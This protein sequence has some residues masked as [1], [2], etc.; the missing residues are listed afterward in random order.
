MSTDT[1]YLS[2]APVILHYVVC[3]LNWLEQKYQI[4]GSFP[5]SWFAGSLPIPPCFHLDARD[6]F[7][8]QND[9]SVR[10][11]GLDTHPSS[12]IPSGNEESVD[13]SSESMKADASRSIPGSSDGDSELVTVSS[14]NHQMSLQTLYRREVL[15]EQCPLH[16]ELLSMRY[17]KNPNESFIS[18]HC[19]VC[20]LQEEQ[21]RTGVLFR[22]YRVQRIVSNCREYLRRC[23]TE[24]AELQYDELRCIATA[25]M[26]HEDDYQP[27][28]THFERRVSNSMMAAHEIKV[29]GESNVSEAGAPPPEAISSAPC[30]DDM[31]KLRLISQAARQYFSIPPSLP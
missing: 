20:A 16:T 30:V 7:I 9:L 4:L 15:F 14:N 6:A 21:L 8:R 28:D 12:S 10:P 11:P 13:V 3:G 24:A 25:D 18:K 26:S 19:A 1:L 29:P 31:D 17:T 23:Q 2:S 22:V 5:D 27:D